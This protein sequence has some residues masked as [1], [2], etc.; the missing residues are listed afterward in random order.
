MNRGVVTTIKQCKTQPKG[1]GY[2]NYSTRHISVNM[3]KRVVIAMSGG[4]IPASPPTAQRTG[5]RSHRAFNMS[6]GTCLEKL[7]P[8]AKPVAAPSTRRTPARWL[9][10]SIYQILHPRLSKPISNSSSTTSAQNMIKAA[11]QTRASGA[12]SISNSGKLLE[13]AD[14]LEADFIATGHYAAGYHE[15]RPISY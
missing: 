15:E 8:N 10:C 14:K 13:Y 4:L 9:I 6:L 3:K 1:C 5:F 12:T 7:A 11:R 2:S